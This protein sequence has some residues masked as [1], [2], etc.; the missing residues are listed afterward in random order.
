MANLL[1][2]YI[3]ENNIKSIDASNPNITFDF[4]E[5]NPDIHYTD[6]D[7]KDNP[8]F[9]YEVDKYLNDCF[10]KSNPFMVKI[11]HIVDRYRHHNF[12]RRKNGLNYEEIKK[13]KEYKK[14]ESETIYYCVK[15]KDEV[16]AI[17][18][19][20]SRQIDTS[21]SARL[22]S[23]SYIT[24]ELIYKLIKLD[25]NLDYNLL[26]LTVLFTEE[27]IKLCKI[28]KFKLNYNYLSA[29]ASVSID[30]ILNNRFNDW[31]YEK[32]SKNPNITQD[33]IDKY[34]EINW[35]SHIKS[36]SLT[37]NKYVYKN[38]IIEYINNS[39]LIINAVKT[40]IVSYGE[41]NLKHMDSSWLPSL[42]VQ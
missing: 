18:R 13:Y 25:I 36:N 41:Y 14:F 20:H 38:K 30:Y 9:W 35:D 29:H 3:L 23:S 15:N 17:F 6:W 33:I 34:P 7:L 39:Q 28:K 5:A 26:S 27:M 1:Q 2:R 40:I 24:T 8:H 42:Y 19:G 16:E 21:F 12:K 31:S 32:I 4:L 22:S 10:D 37:Y 11:S